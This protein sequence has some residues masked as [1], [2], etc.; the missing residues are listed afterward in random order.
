MPMSPQTKGWL[1]LG[2]LACTAL[3][4]GGPAVVA[5]AATI[6]AARYNTKNSELTCVVT[7]TPHHYINSTISVTEFSTNCS[8]AQLLEE[9]KLP[10]G[11]RLFF[12]EHFPYK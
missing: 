12:L 7:L 6:I 1:I 4:G 8:F 11:N 3:T 2:L 10:Q 9:T 5:G